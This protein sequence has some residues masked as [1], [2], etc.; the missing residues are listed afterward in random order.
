MEKSQNTVHDNGPW[1]LEEYFEIG[2]MDFFSPQWNLNHGLLE[3]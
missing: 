3:L 2:L 1:L